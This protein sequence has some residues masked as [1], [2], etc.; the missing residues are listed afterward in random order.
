[1]SNPVLYPNRKLSDEAQQCEKEE[2]FEKAAELYAQSYELF[3]SGFVASKYMKCLCKLERAAQAVEFGR[4]AIQ[5]F[6][7]N[8]YVRSAFGWAG[9]DLHLKKSKATES[10][11]IDED[12]GE[13]ASD[14]DF[15][16]MKKVTRYILEK[17]NDPEDKY[18]RTK[19]V[20]ALMS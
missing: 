1:M 11:D 7:E 17:C 5:D 16:S 20:L 15:S 9:H 3:A 8:K 13:I 6:P 18:L 4:Q 12:S 19:A 10:N 2:N 14:V